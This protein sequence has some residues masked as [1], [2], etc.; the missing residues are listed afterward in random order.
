MR[1]RGLNSKISGLPHRPGAPPTGNIP[2]EELVLPFAFAGIRVAMER[3]MKPWIKTIADGDAKGELLKHYDAAI[4][5]AGKVYGIVRVMSLR[6]DHIRDSMGFYR[7]LMFAPSDL[8]RAER[9]MIAVVVS[10][11]NRCHY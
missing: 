3:T 6:P 1:N 7:T 10:R 2:E 4:A 8:S 5:R 11:A 9:E